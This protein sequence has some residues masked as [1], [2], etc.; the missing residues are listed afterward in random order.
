MKKREE[1]FPCNPLTPSAS[2][3]TASKKALIE[4]LAGP[5]SIINFDNTK[6]EE[7]MAL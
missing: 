3:V 7:L 4:V 1:V 5:S 6:T 2:I